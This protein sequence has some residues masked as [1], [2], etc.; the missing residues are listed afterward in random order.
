[1][2]DTPS[3]L[4]ISTRGRSFR[5]STQ[6]LHTLAAAF[7]GSSLCFPSFAQ[8]LS[9]VSVSATGD[10]PDQA[11]FDADVTADGRW[12]VF[13]SRG[14]NL[15]PGDTNDTRDI[16]LSEVETGEITRINTGPAGQQTDSYSGRP[17]ISSDGRYVVYYNTSDVILEEDANGFTD[18]YLFDRETGANELVSLSSTGAQGNDDSFFAR[19]TDDGRYVV[20]TSDAS[21][22]VPGDTNGLKDVFVRDRQLGETYRVSVSSSGAEADDEPY[23]ASIS[24][25]GR[26][27]TFDN[28]ATNLVA[29]GTTGF[30]VYLHDRVTA[31]TTLVSSGLGG[32]GG[33]GTSWKTRISGDGKWLTF[34]SRASDLVVGD[35]NG[36]KDIF[37]YDV[38]SG[39]T[40]LVSVNGAGEQGDDGSET[41]S[42]SD[43]GRYISYAS[44]ADNLVAG[45]ISEGSDQ[46][47]FVY[48]R[49]TGTVTLA[50]IGPQGQLSD[51]FLSEV[52]LSPE[53]AWVVYNTRSA[54]LSEDING[55]TD[56]FIYGPL[57][58]GLAS[59]AQDFEGLDA[60]EGTALAADGWKVFT[61]VFNPDGS[62]A[63]GYGVFDAP[64]GGPGW[65]AIQ[66]GAGGLYQGDQAL[67]VYSD[68]GNADHGSGM[69]IDAL[70]FQEQE[71]GPGDVGETW[72]M[73]FDQ[74]QSPP[75]SP[76]STTTRAFIKVLRQSDLSFAELYLS[77]FDTT[78][79][80]QMAWSSAALDITLEPAWEGELLQ[81]GFASVATNYEDSGRFYD[82]IDWAPI[83]NPGI[84]RVVCLGNPTSAGSA[85]LLT[86]TGSAVAAD[87]DLT[88][89]VD[90][91][92]ANQMGLF[93]QSPTGITVYNPIGSA[94]HLC[95]ASFEIGRFPTVLDSGA[96]GSVSTSLDLTALPGAT[97][98]ITVMAGNTHQ[99]QYWSR[100]IAPPGSAPGAPGSNFSS[101]VSVTFE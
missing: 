32:Q 59:Y 52:Q 96:A 42:I 26:F 93:C 45:V 55:Q 62:Y 99:F 36:A 63:Y 25:D 98:P 24:N 29:G 85:A 73:R 43:D 77:E 9:L 34:E 17:Q 13:V 90:G 1:M 35:V 16:F 5:T 74:L 78:L 56:V 75:I 84:G 6:A 47:A 15:L 40:S 53:G 71:I 89:T 22:L 80:S 83:A 61:N 69:L 91:L 50:S 28:D 72:R 64:N 14:T 4:A 18:I 21:N 49:M 44:R 38:Q 66:V 39:Q 3:T 81:F 20:F 92:P 94:G 7:L 79:A 31:E 88:L 37:L 2:L 51:N 19:L 87:N 12:V 11:S 46:N 23:T 58:E 95:I 60:A 97:G 57:F 86:A 67:S 10:Q 41:P 70:V 8:E 65:S 82:N 27:V 48:D 68:Y 101:A 30:E 54:L 33:D 100:D 76:G